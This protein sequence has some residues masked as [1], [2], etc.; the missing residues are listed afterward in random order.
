MSGS[1]FV[2]ENGNYQIDFSTAV[3]STDQTHVEFHASGT[4]LS[5]V[6]FVAT[7]DNYTYLV[8]YKNAN[9]TNAANPASFQ[10]KD[11]KRVDNIARKYYDSLHYLAVEGINKPIKYIYIVEYPNAGKTDRKMLRNKISRKLPF[12]LQSNKAKKIIEVFD[13]VSISEWNEHTEY[14]QFPLTPVLQ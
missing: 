7:T 14:S 4:F 11:E 2:E 1:V 8:E 12:R 3:W 6:D 5:D 10:P 13:V 9:V